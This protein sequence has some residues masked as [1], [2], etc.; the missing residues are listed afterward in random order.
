MIGGWGLLLIFVLALAGAFGVPV[1]AVG[2]VVRLCE[3]SWGKRGG[4]LGSTGLLAC[5]AVLA[6]PLVAYFTLG[7]VFAALR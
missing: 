7:W 6:L 5:G 4:E 1:F 3:A 2:V